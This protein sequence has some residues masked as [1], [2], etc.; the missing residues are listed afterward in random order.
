MIHTPPP[1]EI[2]SQLKDLAEKTPMPTWLKQNLL[3]I[4]QNIQLIAP[5]EAEETEAPIFI[6]FH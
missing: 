6:Y 4:S 5:H 3:T 2:A 1:E